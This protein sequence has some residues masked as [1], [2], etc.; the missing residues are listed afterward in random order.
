MTV[1]LK[2]RSP[3]RSYTGNGSSVEET[4]VLIGDRPIWCGRF[5][6]LGLCQLFPLKSVS[7]RWLR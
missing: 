3:R 5:T 7:W 2:M 6:R 1:A 4:E